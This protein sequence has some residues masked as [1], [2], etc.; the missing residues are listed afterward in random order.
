MRGVTRAFA[1]LGG[2]AACGLLFS[3]TVKAADLEPAIDDEPGLLWYGSL[4][5]GP[6]WGDGD[7]KIEWERESNPCYLSSL[8]CVLQPLVH[9]EGELRGEVD[10]GFIFG[11]T[12]GAK[13][14][15]HFRSEIEVSGA[16]LE[17]ESKAFEYV[18]YSPP[19]LGTTYKAEDEDHLREL[20]ILANAW[21]DFQL[22]SMFCAYLGGGAGVARVDAEF[23]TD[24]FTPGIAQV[25]PFS[26]S[27]EA[28]DWAFAYQLG[29]GLLIGLSQHVGIDVGY[30]FKAITN[31]ELDFP[32]F[33]GGE[34]C[35]PPVVHSKADDDFD[36][37][38]HVAHIGLIFTF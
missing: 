10:D 30:R 17:T 6:K 36:I 19:P 22:S 8:I 12:L 23:G 29:A 25:S 4:F 27:I 21:V 5:G 16:R 9:Q 26:A 20:F 32:E 34:H 28:D 2:L 7:I 13:L 11:G 1:L 37:H 3:P 18:S 24:P 15:E 38:E 35:Y 31:V 14:G 33:C